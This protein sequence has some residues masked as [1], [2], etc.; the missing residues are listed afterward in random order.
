MAGYKELNSSNFD[1]TVAEGVSVVDFWAPWCGPCRTL[2]PIIEKLAH[3]YPD[4]KVGKLNVDENP[5]IAE[6]YNVYSI[7]TLLI[8]KGG[9]LVEQV[10]GL[11]P[12]HVLEQKIKRFL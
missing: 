5:D 11:Q 8:F 9:N 6:R 12:K 2:A 10:I 3:K 7:P 1:A 4:I